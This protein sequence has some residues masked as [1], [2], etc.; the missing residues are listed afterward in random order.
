VYYEGPST[1][2]PIAD[3]YTGIGNDQLSS[4]RVSPGFRVTLWEAATEA[5]NGK[6][7]YVYGGD[8]CFNL[9][10]AFEWNDAVSAITL[11]Y[12]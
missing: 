7:A 6:K 9:H 2:V 10:S 4:L 12:C 3:F 8:H 1:F 5:E 11:E